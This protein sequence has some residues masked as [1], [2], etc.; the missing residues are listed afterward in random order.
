LW[1]SDADRKVETAAGVRQNASGSAGAPPR[2]SSRSG[3]GCVSV[4]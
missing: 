2:H 1:V 3:S 4:S